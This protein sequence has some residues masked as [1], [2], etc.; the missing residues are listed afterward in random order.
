MRI[1]INIMGLL[2]GKSKDKTLKKIEKVLKEYR[3]LERPL[4][5]QYEDREDYYVDLHEYDFHV[6][7][8]QEKMD[9]LQHLKGN[10]S[11]ALED[12]I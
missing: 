4:P 12:F 8:L 7:L 6:R 11:I 2:T 1:N 5:H 3:E 9:Y 10:P